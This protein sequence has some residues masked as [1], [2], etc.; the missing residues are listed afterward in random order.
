MTHIHQTPF[1]PQIWDLERWSEL[2][3]ASREEAEYWQRSSCGILCLKMAVE[4]V[5]GKDID[6]VAVL[7]AKGKTLDAY[8]HEL[9]WAHQGLA[10][11]AR[12]Y[13]VHAFARERIEIEDIKQYIDKGAL[14]I[15]S[16]KWAFRPPKGFKEKLIFWKKRGGH[17]ALVVGYEEGQGF[18][19]NHTSVT[20]GYNWER[21][22]VPFEQF[23]KG[24][25]GRGVI[26][27]PRGMI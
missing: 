5:L 14:P 17:L 26:I 9:G 16:I 15:I 8:S 25:T 12:A 10:E 3:F 22:F 21:K 4:G 7:I 2:G 1:Y 27:A 20:E 18:Y 24:F 13:G 19:V 6:P 23:K 11:L